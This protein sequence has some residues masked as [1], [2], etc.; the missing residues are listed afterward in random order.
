MREER[1]TLFLFSVMLFV[2]FRGLKRGAPAGREDLSKHP[3]E[4]SRSQTL[5]CHKE[6]QKGRGGGKL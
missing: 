6:V 2:K 4:G 3:P 5:P 1:N